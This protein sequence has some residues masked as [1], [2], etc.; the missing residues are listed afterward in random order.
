MRDL[1]RYEKKFDAIQKTILLLIE[2]YSALG[3]NKLMGSRQ[4]VLDILEALNAFAAEQFNFF[5]MGFN[6]G[7][8]RKKIP[9]LHEEVSGNNSGILYP[10]ESVLGSILEQIASDLVTIQLAA[11][12]RLLAEKG[13][14]PKKPVQLGR[15]EIADTGVGLLK[16]AENYCQTALWTLYKKVPGQENEVT[17]VLP[18]VTDSVKIR[19]TPYA[20]VAL[21]GIPY[22]CSQDLR[23]FLAVPHEVGHYRYWFP[24]PVSTEVLPPDKKNIPPGRILN[25]RELYFPFDPDKK[26]PAWTE[27][28]FADVYA[29]LVG[30]RSSILTAMALALEHSQESFSDLDFQ[31]PHPTPL[32]RPLL[33]IKALTALVT[34]VRGLQPLV[35]LKKQNIDKTTKEL[36]NEWKR[37][38]ESRNILTITGSNEDDS[39][40]LYT[41]FVDQ[42]SEFQSGL[43]QLIDWNLRTLDSSRIAEKLVEDVVWALSYLFESQKQNSGNWGWSDAF[44]EKVPLKEFKASAR[45]TLRKGVTTEHLGTTA[46]IKQRSWEDWVTEKGYFDAVRPAEMWAGEFQSAMDPTKR[47]SGSWLPIFGAGGWSTGGP[48]GDPGRP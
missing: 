37:L 14:N 2:R 13:K 32:L 33:M 30:G 41:Q 40:D 42:S 31:K 29:L 7:D 23:S 20:P 35:K 6:G 24:F 11:E 5:Y 47:P 16:G 19:V 12:Q 17:K 46:R 15:L 4:V 8:K 44:L 48:C 43:K 27:E 25:A 39:A 38:V 28:I 10:A 36:F 26:R 45:P 22:T 18:Y 1:E 34:G 21:I 9:L 3:D